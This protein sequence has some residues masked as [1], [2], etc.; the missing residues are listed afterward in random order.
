MLV[1]LFVFLLLLFLFL[2]FPH[3]V[4]SRLSGNSSIPWRPFGIIRA[5]PEHFRRGA[6]A[7]EHPEAGKPPKA[8]EKVR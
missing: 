1:F 2:L 3:F 7:R 8:D 6:A 4:A 5:P